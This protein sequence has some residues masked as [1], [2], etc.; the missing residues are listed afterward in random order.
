MVALY[1]FTPVS[2][3][4]TNT[5]RVL[6]FETHLLSEKLTGLIVG[7]MLSTKTPYLPKLRVCA[8]ILL[9]FILAHS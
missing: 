9:P 1:F 3:S 2:L 8:E 4:L 7:G 5:C 6:L